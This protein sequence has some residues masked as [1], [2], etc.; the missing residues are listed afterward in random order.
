[1]KM[2]LLAG[3]LSFSLALSA[4]GGIPAKTPEES[5]PEEAVVTEF[6]FTT[7]T[8][9]ADVMANPVFGDYGRLLFPVQDAYYSGETLGE[10]RLT[11]YRNIDPDMTVEILNALHDRAAAGETVFYDI[12]TD[13]EKAAVPL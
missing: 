12:Y 11:Y 7:D 13:A 8:P 4:C 2:M 1:M 6:P 10:L 9:I 5:V 3:L